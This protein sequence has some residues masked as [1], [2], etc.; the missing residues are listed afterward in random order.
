[1]RTL[2]ALGEQFVSVNGEWA[3]FHP[4]ILLASM[5]AQPLGNVKQEKSEFS[6]EE[7]DITRPAL[8]PLPTGLLVVG[9][10]V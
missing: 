6:N 10:P 4:R 3:V 1:M 2:L 7:F 8:F 9:T 5:Y